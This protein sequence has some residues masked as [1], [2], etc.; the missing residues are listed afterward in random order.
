MH[1]RQKLKLGN[2]GRFSSYLPIVALP[3]IISTLYFNQVIQPKIF[4]E[5]AKCPLCLQLQSASIQSSFS[6]I[7][8]SLLAPL[9]GFMF[10]TRHFTYRLPSIT[11]KPMDVL[12]V[13]MKLTKPITNSLLILAGINGLVAMY[14]T[15][16]QMETFHFVKGKLIE[17]EKD[18]EHMS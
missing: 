9:S 4:L 7:L 12:R 13:Y 14:I 16:K 6:V 17:F 2:Y 3:A 15:Y 5:K 1:Y 11:E 10:A 8:P 18:H